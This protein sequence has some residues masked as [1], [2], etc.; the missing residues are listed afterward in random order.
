MQAHQNAQTVKLQ[1]NKKAQKQLTRLMCHI[2]SLLKLSDRPVYTWNEDVFLSVWL[3]TQIDYV[4]YR[5]KWGLNIISLPTFDHADAR[6]KDVVWQF[7]MT[8]HCYLGTVM[9]DYTKTVLGGNYTKKL[10]LRPFRMAITTFQ[11]LCNDISLMEKSHT[12]FWCVWRNLLGKCVSN[13][14]YS[15]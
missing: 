1:N 11:V 8:H 12:F 2:S 15:H 7:T 9:G 10:W 6:T 5:C 3:W 4:K 13:S 14:H